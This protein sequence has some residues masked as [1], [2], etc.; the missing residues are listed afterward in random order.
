MLATAP[1]GQRGIWRKMD[2]LDG[3]TMGIYIMEI[4]V[5]LS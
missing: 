2:L 3:K 5:L 1:A 4:M